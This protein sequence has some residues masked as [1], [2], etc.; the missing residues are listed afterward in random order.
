MRKLREKLKD[1]LFCFMEQGVKFGHEKSF[2]TK[3]DNDDFDGWLQ[4]FQLS[5]TRKL[6]WRLPVDKSKHEKS[7]QC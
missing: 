4:F 5:S 3:D 1:V 2:L 6:F 7:E